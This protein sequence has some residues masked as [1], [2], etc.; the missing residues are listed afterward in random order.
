MKTEHLFHVWQLTIKQMTSLV[1]WR[2]C[3]S[4]GSS[5]GVVLSCVTRHTCHTVS[6]SL[7]DRQHS[8]G[9]YTSLTLQFAASNIRLVL[10]HYFMLST[11]WNS[12][13][14]PLCLV[15][16]SPQI[17]CIDCGSSLVVVLV[18]VS[19]SCLLAKHRDA[20]LAEIH[21]SISALNQAGRTVYAELPYLVGKCG[22]LVL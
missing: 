21:P 8:Y 19:I 15:E 2:R 13:T 10:F 12:V 1:R 14:T 11:A 17:S 16:N 5:Y 4:N 7:T 18:F 22:Q 3:P 9:D 20:H 6:F